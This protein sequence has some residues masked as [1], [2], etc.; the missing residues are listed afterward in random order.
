M[1][2]FLTPAASG[3]TTG[4]AA[5]MNSTTV[6]LPALATQTSPEPS[7]ATARGLLRIVEFTGPPPL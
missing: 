3:V 5:P 7:M 2:L 1:V 4:V 6:L